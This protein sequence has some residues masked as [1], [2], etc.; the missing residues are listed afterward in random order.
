ML[1]RSAQSLLCKVKR[2]G[3]FETAVVRASITAIPVASTVMDIL[4]KKYPS[5]KRDV[6]NAPFR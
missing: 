4:M 5:C 6:T 2:I 3:G 1:P